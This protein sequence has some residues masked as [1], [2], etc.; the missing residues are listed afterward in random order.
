ML[1]IWI[2]NPQAVPPDTS[3]GTRHYDLA[4]ELVKRGHKVS[5]FASSF[6][7]ATLRE[8]RL[9]TGEK[10]KKQFFDGVRFIW[11]KT[12]PYTK[13]DLHRF[14]NILI[15][16]LRLMFVSLKLPE[17]PDI[18]IGSSPPPFPALFA[19]FLARMRGSIFFFEDRDLWGYSLPLDALDNS[20]IA[21]K[22]FINISKM[23]EKFLYKKSDKIVVAPPLGVLWL[24]FLG[25]S[26]EKIVNIPNGVDLESFYSSQNPLSADLEMFIRSAKAQGYF[27]VVFT[28]PL[29]FAFALDTLLKAA[30]LLKER[31]Y[32]KIHFLFIGEGPDK[33][34]LVQLSESLGL[35]NVHFFSPIP[36]ASIPTLLKQCDS[37][38]ALGKGLRYRWLGYSSSNKLVSYMAA[39][40]PVIVTGQTLDPI[41]RRLSCGIEVEPESAEALCEAIIKLYNMDSK[42]RGEMGKR[43]LE[44]IRKERDIPILANKLLEAIYKR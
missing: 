40:K 44:Y 14:W 41:V 21:I 29:R 25:I 5:I 2:V 42:A 22:V 1:N 15:F 10:W 43:G 35:K 30:K 20:S 13:N 12:P 18:I 27:L 33:P 23:I 8:E 28:G 7:H 9:S 3:G 38:I 31:G 16:S 37:T 36:K 24:K 34:R 39:A 19:Y 4:K 6:N 32:D 11:L 26:P 17:K